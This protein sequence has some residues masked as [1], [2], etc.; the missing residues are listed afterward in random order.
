M[1][2]AEQ[3]RKAVAAA[4]ELRAKKLAR[5]AEEAADRTQAESSAAGA[6]QGL[7]QAQSSADGGIHGQGDVVFG[8]AIPTLRTL[9]LGQ[10]KSEF[11]ACMYFHR[12]ASSEDLELA[13]KIYEE[14]KSIIEGSS[15]AEFDKLHHTFLSR[16]A[17]VLRRVMAG[18]ES[19]VF[20]AT[21]LAAGQG[22]SWLPQNYANRETVKPMTPSDLNTEETMLWNSYPLR[23]EYK[24][25]YAE[26]ATAV[27][28]EFHD[29]GHVSRGDVPTSG[30]HSQFTTTN[31]RP[32]FGGG[33]FQTPSVRLITT[34][35]SLTRNRYSGSQSKWQLRA[36]LSEVS[37]HPWSDW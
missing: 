13:T 9:R 17:V 27:R 20:M 34:V 25:P 35:Q 7:Q 23:K 16:M 30:V 8:P 5:E 22:I 19:A 33:K 21:G 3:T 37:S 29:L 6:A 2:S 4:E 14:V 31:P 36:V 1:P 15:L 12:N 32:A 18:P 10:L 24:D 11:D 28:H 26:V